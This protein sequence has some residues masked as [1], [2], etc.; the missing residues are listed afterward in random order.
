MKHNIKIYN[1]LIFLHDNW[2]ALKDKLFN[3]CKDNGDD[4]WQTD[5][6]FVQYMYVNYFQDEPLTRQLYNLDDGNLILVIRFINEELTKMLAD[7]ILEA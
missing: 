2:D 5:N 1:G 3:W 7:R 4:R 6:D